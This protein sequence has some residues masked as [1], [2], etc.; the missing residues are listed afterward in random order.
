MFYVK[1]H[2]SEEGCVLAVCDREVL[3]ETLEEGE[4]ALTVSEPFYKGELK[5]KTRALSRIKSADNVNLVGNRIVKLAVENGLVDEGNVMKVGGVSHAI[6][7]R[8]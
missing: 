4:L 6:V 5:S 3:G 8:F 7:L 1:E 2:S